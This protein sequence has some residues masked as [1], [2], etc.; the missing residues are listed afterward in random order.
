MF[1]LIVGTLAL[2][3]MYRGVSRGI[4]HRDN[5]AIIESAALYLNIS[6]VS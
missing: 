4:Y 5:M 3:A 2:E 6:C 1:H